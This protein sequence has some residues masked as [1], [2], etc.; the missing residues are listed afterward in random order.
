MGPERSNEDTGVSITF[1]RQKL[2]HQ[3]GSDHVWST[4]KKHVFPQ[5][6]TGLKVIFKLGKRD[7]GNTYMQKAILKWGFRD[8]RWFCIGREDCLDVLRT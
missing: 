1:S 4:C 7:S 6:M 3:T 2:G 8:G 5:H